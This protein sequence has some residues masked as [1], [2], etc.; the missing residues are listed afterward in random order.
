MRMMVVAFKN[1]ATLT[2]EH[3][4]W[5]SF[6]KFAGLRHSNLLKK[7]TLAKLFSCVFYLKNFWERLFF[8]RTPQVAASSFS[9]PVFPQL[10]HYHKIMKF[11]VTGMENILHSLTGR[12]LNILDILSYK[13]IS[14]A[15]KKVADDNI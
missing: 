8:Y 2:G 4:C 1:F 11:Q 10:P 12:Q 7:E 5:S 6:H 15:V 13:N 14:S 3:L 9:F